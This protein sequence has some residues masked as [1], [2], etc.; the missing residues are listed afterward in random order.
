MPINVAVALVLNDRR[1]LLLGTRKN[2]EEAGLF[3]FPGGKQDDWETIEKT[4]ARELK[5]ETNLT[6]AKCEF[7]T[8]IDEFIHNHYFA[9]IF[10][11]TKWSGTL[12][13]M[14][15]EKCGG[16][17]WYGLDDLP[18]WHNR[19]KLFQLLNPQIMTLNK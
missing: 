11:V 1:E 8:Y 10:L 7:L 17:G 14:E 16:W 15:P 19:T 13:T 3:G 12:K 9:M 6:A 4:L 5:E 2:P 18:L